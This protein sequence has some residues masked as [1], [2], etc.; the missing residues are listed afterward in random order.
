MP[1]PLLLPV[2]TCAV[3]L[4]VSGVAKL[5]APSSVEVAFT[6]M[7]VPQALDT[8]LV[9]RAVPWLEVA[10]GVWLLLATGTPLAVVA[11]LTLLLFVA[12]LA[13]VVVAVRA[14]EPADCG[15][16]GAIGD[17]RVTRVT[18]WRNA[19]LVVAAL[20]AVAA[21]LRGVGLLPAVLEEPSTW[22]W[23]A[24]AALAVGIAVLVTHRSERTADPSAT[25]EPH[26]DDAG[27]YVRRPI[28]LAVVQTEE[29]DLVLLKGVTQRAAHLLVFLSP[30]CGPCGRINPL[31]PG[32]G[33]ELAPVVVKAVLA[34]NPSIV[35]ES[36]PHLRGHAW[37]DPWGVARGEFGKGYPGAVLIGADGYLAGGPVSGEQDVMDLVAAIGEQL[38]EAREAEELSVVPVG[39]LDAPVTDAR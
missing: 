17:S 9:R 8:P 24:T 15:C 31:V 25:S 20:L 36:F 34:A 19:L 7:R 13:L 1:S 2:V 22:G 16:F 11:V 37:F 21:G 28:P 35:D 4:L 18:V 26:L 14:P 23:L 33:E 32:W 38:A 30:H 12:Y 3:V 10:L 29:K 6:S 5:Q 27:E 39:D